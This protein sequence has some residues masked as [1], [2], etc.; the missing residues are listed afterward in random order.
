[1]STIL[2][3]D[4]DP[5]ICNLVTRFLHKEGFN[6]VTAPNG[7]EGLRLAKQIKPQAITLD[8]MMPGMDGWATLKQLKSDLELKQIPVA[9]LTQLDERGLGFSLGAD[10]YLFKPINWET[11]GS[12]IK[13]WVRKKQHDPIIVVTDKPSLQQQLHTVLEKQG[14]R[15]TTVE[16]GKLAI[17]ALQK[18]PSSLIIF[19]L[20]T[21]NQ[22]CHEFMTLLGEN[23]YYNAIPVVALTTAE[24]S[25]KEQGLLEKEAISSVLIE[26]TAEQEQ[27]LN[28][29]RALLKSN[30][31]RH[32]AA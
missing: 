32:R 4:D 13:K 19:E 11:L 29:I 21:E 23:D 16:S 31:A 28:K 25:E 5:N 9:M 18:Q 17:K 22:Q 12:A 20:D 6:V 8:V 1:M 27:L 7:K 3:I 10:D 14:Y 26:D 2:V 15:V 30:G 24:L